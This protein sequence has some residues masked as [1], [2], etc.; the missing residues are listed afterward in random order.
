[1][2]FFIHLKVEIVLAIPS[3]N[4]WKIEIIQQDKG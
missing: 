4:E 2:L 3:S 1:M